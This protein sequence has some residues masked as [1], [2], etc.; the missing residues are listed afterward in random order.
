MLWIFLEI[1]LVLHCLIWTNSHSYKGR[2]RS[3]H[4]LFSPVGWWANPCQS[5]LVTASSQWEPP[6]HV[7][8]CL[9]VLRCPRSA[10]LC[11]L[12]RE[13]GKVPRCVNPNCFWPWV[14]VKESKT[15]ELGFNII[16]R[17]PNSSKAKSMQTIWIPLT[18]PL[19]FWAPTQYS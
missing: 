12:I 4:L 10:P 11:K 14:W 6:L 13:W 9:W 5:T 7:R 1:W 2:K 15:L 19:A 8:I 17:C 16:I 3:H 18:E